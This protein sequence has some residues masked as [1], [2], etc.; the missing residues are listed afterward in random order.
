MYSRVVN[1]NPEL[2]TVKSG[3]HASVF[4]AKV[5]QIIIHP[6]YSRQ[7]RSN[8][9]SLLELE[10]ELTFDESKKAIELAGSNDRYADR[11]ICLTTG[12]GETNNNDELSFTLRG[13]ELPI[14]PQADCNKAY[15]EIGGITERMI[16]AGFRR[17]GKDSK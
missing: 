8:D 14:Y 15:R 9:F 16:C 17:G 13:V 11:S 4:V 3:T 12:W 7:T 5:K 6:E 10:D 2:I 1:N